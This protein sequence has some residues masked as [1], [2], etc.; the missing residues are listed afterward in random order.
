MNRVVGKKILRDEI[1]PLQIITP[2]VT[3]ND[4]D[5]RYSRFVSDLK[6]TPSK[7]AQSAC[8]KKK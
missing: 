8:E 4:K 3:F 2:P 6:A 7:C 1:H 5:R